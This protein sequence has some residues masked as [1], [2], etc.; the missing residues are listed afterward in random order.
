MF[1]EELKHSFN[2]Q[3]DHFQSIQHELNSGKST[4]NY[5]GT[6]VVNQFRTRF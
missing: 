5:L 1:Y 2:S 3:E 6:F 4:S